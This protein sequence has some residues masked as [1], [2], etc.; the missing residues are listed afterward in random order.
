LECSRFAARKSREEFMTPIQT[1]KEGSAPRR[2]ILG[3][4]GGMGPLA[5]AD[6]FA[7][8]VA[9][10]PAEDDAMHVPVLVA[11]LPQIPPRVPAILD[12][13]ES[14][15]PMLVAV[16]NRL[17]AA[18][19]TTIAMPCNTAH[20]WYDALSR[21]GPPMLHIADAAITALRRLAPRP[22]R[23]GLVATTGT[24]VSGFYQERLAQA[25]YA[26][27]LPE[28]DDLARDIVPAIAAVKSGRLHQGGEGFVRAARALRV[29]GADAVI[30]ACTEVPPAV[31]A[32]GKPAD[33]PCVDAT[34]A[35][36][37]ACVAAWC[38]GR[39]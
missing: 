12:N 6:F 31:A 15:L 28:A 9:L 25:G 19:A 8:L 10:T 11:S 26:S 2:G 32:V 1:S 18:G 5:T 3:I 7:K 33:V 36:A 13:G 16:R 37:A 39:L 20:H 29:R 35:L 22:A 27:L 34:E 23:V 14:P 4:L 38:E 24:L 21:G 17:V 30:L